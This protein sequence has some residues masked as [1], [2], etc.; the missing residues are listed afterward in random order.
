MHGFIGKHPIPRPAA[1]PPL[2]PSDFLNTR[3][4]SGYLASLHLLDLVQKHPTRNKPIQSLLASG[5]A[6]YLEAAGPVEQHHTGG[7]L[8]D[9]LASMATGSDERFLDI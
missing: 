3:L 5:L 4:L 1:S 9:V 8:I 7:G 2:L 6:L